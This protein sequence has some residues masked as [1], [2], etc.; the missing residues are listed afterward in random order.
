LHDYQLENIPCVLAGENVLFF[1]ATGYGKSSLYDI[2]LLVHV[3][4][5]ENLTLYPAFPVREYPVA[6]VVTPTKGLANS[7]V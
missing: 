3:E 4:I 1:A 7:I 6:V 2:P 5:R